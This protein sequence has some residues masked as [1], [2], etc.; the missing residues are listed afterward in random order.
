MWNPDFVDSVVA[1]GRIL[2][3]YPSHDGGS[4]SE[5]AS[6]ARSASSDRRVHTVRKGET[7]SAIA[8]TYGIPLKKLQSLNGGTDKIFVGKKVRLR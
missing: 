6:V 3:I 2:T 8:R 4:R 1:P 5:Q 7:L